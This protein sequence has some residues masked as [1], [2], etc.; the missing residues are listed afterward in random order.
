MLLHY[1]EESNG[2]FL[3]SKIQLLF[4]FS[5]YI[6]NGEKNYF[7]TILQVS[8]SLQTDARLRQTWW[9]LFVI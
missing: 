6:E 7:L 4:I 5:S 1:N 8:L 2:S 9:T 3:K